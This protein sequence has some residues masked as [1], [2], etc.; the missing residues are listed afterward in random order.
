MLSFLVHLMCSTSSCPCSFCKG[1][2]IYLKVTQVFSWEHCEIFKN[3]YFEE[4]LRTVVIRRA[5]VDYGPVTKD[6]C[7]LILSSLSKERNL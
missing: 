7:P 1:L 6:Y 4:H 5:V 3:T 2:Q